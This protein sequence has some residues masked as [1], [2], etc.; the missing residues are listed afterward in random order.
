MKS[1]EAFITEAK[2]HKQRQLMK[3]EK[4]SKDWYRIAIERDKW[5]IETLVVDVVRNKF[6]EWHVREGETDLGDKLP[7][8]GKDIFI[9]FGSAKLYAIDLAKAIKDEKPYP[10]FSDEKYDV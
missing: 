2:E 7:D 6:G 5:D 4:V 3:F 9:K 10:R 8:K 1:Y